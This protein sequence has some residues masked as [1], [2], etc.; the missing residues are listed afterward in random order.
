MTEHCD[1]GMFVKLRVEKC[2]HALKR[3]GYYQ[4]EGNRYTQE[5]EAAFKAGREGLGLVIERC[6][7]GAYSL[8]EFWSSAEA[9]RGVEAP[10][11]MTIP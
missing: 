3:A 8:A 5:A 2:P 9:P 10:E 11:W 1:C 4:R 6:A 7:Q